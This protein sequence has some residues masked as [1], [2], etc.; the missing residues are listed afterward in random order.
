M[1]DAVHIS[2]DLLSSV[3]KVIRNPHFWAVLVLFAVGVILH[4]P[5]QLTPWSATTISSFLGTTRHTAERVFF[6]I[7][8]TYA[9]FIFGLKGG[10]ASLVAA[11]FIM[12]PRAIFISEVPADAILESIGVI[13]VG[14]VV[15]LWFYM[16]RKN[17]AQRRSIEEALVRIID[18]SSIPLFVINNHHKVTQWN[19]AVEAL[20][21][22]KREEIIGTDEQWRAFYTEKRPVMADLIVDGASKK[23]IE[24]YY[25]NGYKR[26]QLIAGAYEAE[27]WFSALG[28]DGEYLHFTASPIRNSNGEITGA[29]ETLENITERKKAEENLRYYLQ[30]ITKAQEEERKRIARELHDSSAQNL[31]ALLH[32]LDNLLTDK[33]KLP[34]SEAKAL[35]GF[36]E[37]IRD[38]LQEVRRFSRDL[39][40]SI[41]DDLGLL[42]A[43]EWVTDDLKSTYWI[44]VDLKVLGNE[45]RLFPE[46]EL[47]L[48]RIVQ[49]ALRNIAKHAEATMA[50]VKV[51][52]DEDRIAVTIS[53]NGKGFEPPESLGALTPTGKL[54]LAGMQERVQL[55]GGRLKLESKPGKGTKIFVEAPV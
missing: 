23:E 17:I 15:N 7:P 11:G 38:T 8:V 50:E 10:I 54:G 25:K 6:L 20:T 27:G 34:V 19:T 40:P 12:L 13:I 32:Q 47:L 51:K 41:L 30:E 33:T 52:F 14:G 55:L 5:E 46:T 26:N 4:Y 45:R 2:S 36:Y 21:G 35:W 1:G 29:I 16:H 28:K 39:R 3:R 18:G 49:E 31:I 43:L 24:T 37:Q 22:I 42:P 48:F 53:D 44:E 9:S